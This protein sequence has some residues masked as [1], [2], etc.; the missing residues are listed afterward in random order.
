MPTTDNDS[1]MTGEER[2]MFNY[3]KIAEKAAYAAIA[4]LAKMAL[5]GS[6][7][8][9]SIGAISVLIVAVVVL[10]VVGNKRQ[11]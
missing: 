6:A 10:L 5:T 11:K 8:A 4:G 9:V 3:N 1:G 7:D 2:K